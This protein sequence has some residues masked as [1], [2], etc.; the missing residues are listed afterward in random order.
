M[1]EVDNE[2]QR[3]PLL[4]DDVGHAVLKM[5]KQKKQKIK[6]VYHLANPEV[7]TKYDLGL[8]LEKI[9]R[10]R[11][12]LIPATPRERIAKRPK[13]VTLDCSK[14]RKI[15]ISLHSLEE[16]IRIIKSQYQ[17]SFIET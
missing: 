11:S 4:V 6:G 1:L 17:S 8:A 14:A 3:Q 2:Q 15:G 7:M 12:L 16:A 5:L 10:K 13:N 9:V